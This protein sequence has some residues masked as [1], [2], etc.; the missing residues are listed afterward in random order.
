MVKKSIL[1]SGCSSGLGNSLIQP[2]MD[3]GFHVFAGVRKQTDF[4]TIP[5]GAQALKLDVTNSAHIEAAIKTIHTT[6]LPVAGLIN[7]AGVH[8]EGNFETV[9]LENS[10][11]VFDVNFWGAVNL[12]RAILP[13]M[14]TQKFGHIISVS[15]LSGCI[16]LPGDSMYA[17][18]KH[19]LEA[20]MESLSNEVF[21]H[22]IHVTTV[23]PGALDTNLLKGDTATAKAQNSSSKN[24]PPSPHI[25]ACEIVDLLL[26]PPKNLQVPAGDQAKNIMHKFN[27]L[28][29]VERDTLIKNI[30]GIK[31]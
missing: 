2:L 15:S 20:A 29:Q 9:S 17:A 30:S 16:A 14:Q 26:N 7:N 5:K 18:S 4:S 27:G 28:S 6:G 22:N 10:R 1:V 24:T 11:D 31:P 8:V 3:T 23:Q 12:T 19:A 21:H 13:I 25:V